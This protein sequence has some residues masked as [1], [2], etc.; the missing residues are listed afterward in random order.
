MFGLHNYRGSCWVNATLQS[1]FRFPDLQSR[2]NQKKL[3]K[4]NVIEQCLSS[5][6]NSKGEHGLRDFFEAVRT[7][8]MP[9]GIDIG[10][11]HEL[12]H[13]LCDKIPTLDKLCRF[14]IAHVMKCNKC[15]NKVTK[16]DSVIEFSL[17]SVSGNHI[18]LSECISKSVQPYE[19]NEWKCEKCNCIGGTRQQL[20]GTFPKYMIFH[21]PL[22]NTS[23]DYSSIL[24]LNKNKYALSSVIC[25]NGGHWWTYGRNMPPGESWY[26]LDDENV[27]EHGPK[28]FPISSQMRVLIYYRLDE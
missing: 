9:A 8:T 23:I 12:L 11:S 25:F 2:Y 21:A 20:I 27:V 7:D 13:Y 14:R 10:D 22:T 4:N 6:W 28:Q 16:E 24:I 15:D 5:I 26:T 1:L 19:I 17:D 3:D 18:P